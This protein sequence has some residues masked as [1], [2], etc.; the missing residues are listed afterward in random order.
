[1][2][3]NH[4]NGR[5]KRLR[6][7]WRWLI[8]LVALALLGGGIINYQIASSINWHY[9]RTRCVPLSAADY[10]LSVLVL[11]LFIVAIFG[12]WFPVRRPMQ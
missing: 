8:A 12:R 5:G 11:Y 3:D 7:L 4:D 2:S 1:M 6:S 9:F 10:A